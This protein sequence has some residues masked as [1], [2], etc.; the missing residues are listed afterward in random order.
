MGKS[1]DDSKSSLIEQFIT[2]IIETDGGFA[3]IPFDWLVEFSD[4]IKTEYG[5]LPSSEDDRWE[6]VM[7]RASEKFIDDPEDE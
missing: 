3:E 4:E 7:N 2:S 1:T 6:E 5:F